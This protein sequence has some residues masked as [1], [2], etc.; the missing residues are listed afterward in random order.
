MLPSCRAVLHRKRRRMWRKGLLE[1]RKE[2]IGKVHLV[3]NAR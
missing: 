3:I 2:R 1:R